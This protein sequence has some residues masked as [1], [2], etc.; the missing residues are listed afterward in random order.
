MIKNLK[1][2][3]I[4]NNI[5]IVKNYDE[6]KKVYSVFMQEPFYEAWTNEEMEKEYEYLKE[7]G[8]V[9]GYYNGEICGLLNLINGAK[10]DQPVSFRDNDKV[11]YISDIAMRKEF[12]RRG[13]AKYL[14]N[15]LMEYLNNQDYYQ[16]AYLRT[17]LNGSMSEGLFIPKGFEVMKNE[18]GIITQECSFKRT[19]DD[20][21]EV[22]IR[23]FLS[24]K[25]R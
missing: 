20:L 23:K 2:N 21:E 11:L 8:E 3:K 10:S 1:I 4:M 6:F 19:R 25:I 5:E 15:F 7:K 16:D 14:V 22:D 9:L 12:R 17:N 18:K 24:K 13:Y